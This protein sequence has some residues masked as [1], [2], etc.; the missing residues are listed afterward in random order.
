MNDTTAPVPRMPFGRYR[1]QLLSAIPT[2]YLGFLSRLSDL[3]EPLPA[4]VAA[5]VERRRREK[6]DAAK[7]RQRA[8]RRAARSDPRQGTLFT[9]EQ[10]P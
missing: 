7:Q 8:A 2:Y 3:R 6:H 9:M 1:G 10:T 5:E 4:Q